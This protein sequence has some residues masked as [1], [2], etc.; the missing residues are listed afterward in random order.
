MWNFLEE[1]LKNKFCKSYDYCALKYTRGENEKLKKELYAL[2]R[3]QENFPFIC[4]YVNS[5]N[6]IIYINLSSDNNGIIYAHCTMNGN[7]ITDIDFYGRFKV[8]GLSRGDLQRVYTEIKYDKDDIAYC[9]LV[10]FLC[11][12]NRGYGTIM[13]TC[14][15]NYLQCFNV[16]YI[17]GFVSDVDVNDVNDKEHGN[18]LYHFYKKFGFYFYT[19]GNVEYMRLDLPKDDKLCSRKYIEHSLYEEEN[20]CYNELVTNLLIS[21]NLHL[22]DLSRTLRINN[23]NYYIYAL[24][25]CSTANSMIENLTLLCEDIDSLE[26]KSPEKDYLLKRLSLFINPVRYFEDDE[27]MIL[28]AKKANDKY[29]AQYENE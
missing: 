10:D 25:V 4:N 3:V 5:E 19:K 11:T 20:D 21:N 28:F 24:K 1:L 14:L 13:M 9:E 7:K 15:I 27:N 17:K 12:G 18:R 23:P 29:L 26:S 22:S 2:K 6:Q 8:N 16:S